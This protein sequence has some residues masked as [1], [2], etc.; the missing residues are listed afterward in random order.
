MLWRKI[1]QRKE[2][3]RVERAVILSR[4]VW[5]GLIERECLRKDLRMREVAMELPSSRC[6]GPEAHNV[7]CVQRSSRKSEGL[8][9]WGES[10]R[11]L[12][13]GS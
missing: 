4:V 3:G 10:R 9:E 11:R 8:G 1:R 6:K 5:E 7:Q 2:I 13:S 12:R